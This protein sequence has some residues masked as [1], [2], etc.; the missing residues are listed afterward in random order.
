LLK[1][2]LEDDDAR[3]E[4]LRAHQAEQGGAG[5]MFNAFAFSK[6]SN[7][8]EP[9]E[10]LLEEEDEGDIFGNLVSTPSK[11]KNRASMSDGRLSNYATSPGAVSSRGPADKPRRNGHQKG[12]SIASIGSSI[13]DSTVATTYHDTVQDN[14]PLPPLP[15][16]KTG[17]ETAA[18]LEEPLVDEIAC[19][20]R[21]SGALL[22]QYLHK[23]DYA[24]FQSVK[25]HIE[26]LHLGRRQLLSKSLSVDE[27]SRLRASLVERLH[28]SSLEQGLDL[29][30]RHPTWGAMADV[31]AYGDIDRKAWMSGVRMY[32]MAVDMAYS[33]VSL[34]EKG[35][36]TSPV[37][38][39]KSGAVGQSVLDNMFI[40]GDNAQIAKAV[41][42]DT[43]AA[44][45]QHYHLLIDLK[46][47]FASPCQP[48]ETAELLFSLYNKAENRFMTEECCMILNH[49][50]GTCQ[51][52]D[53]E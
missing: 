42:Q 5:S 22:Y 52:I 15:S 39:K 16:L 37:A 47:F 31:E 3:L 18:G 32:K 43:M 49:Q 12:A 34:R 26:A 8:K 10:P 40:S 11:A 6:S 9:L 4:Q 35:S 23:R 51:Q 45:R 29:V 30:V 48:G 27:L 33:D 19:A 53:S 1:E 14:R 2:R 13:P 28:R 20:I 21:E 38:G 7:L 41:S 24:M 17:D 50:G 25:A 46:A 36:A 44:L